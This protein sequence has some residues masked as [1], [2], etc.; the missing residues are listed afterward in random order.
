MSFVTT[1][2]DA[3]VGTL[4]L[5][6]EFLP[7][8]LLT[9]AVLVVGGFLAFFLRRGV[10]WVFTQLRI[11]EGSEAIGLQPIL[12]RGGADNLPGFFGWVVAWFTIIVTFLV[13]L[14]LMG[15][16]RV[17]AFFAP[18]GSYVLHVVVAVLI[19]IV[20]LTIANFLSGIIRSSVRIA[21][22]TSANFLANAAWLAVFIFTL[23]IALREL[24][25]PA[26]LIQY[27]VIGA[28]AALAL[29]TGI[30]FGTGKESARSWFGALQRDLT[31]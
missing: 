18:L 25:V 6:S 17:I 16:V 21:R 30:A 24:Q 20:G 9:I 3:T 8:F 1:L 15:L 19:L 29:A 11:N 31:E 7:R 12:E 13:A 4:G 14:N 23:L 5:L 27:I 28:I 2:T 26:S 22:L 10:I